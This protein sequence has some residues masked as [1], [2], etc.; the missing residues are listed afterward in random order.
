MEKMFHLKQMI[1]EKY[2]LIM[3]VRKYKG[4]IMKETNCLKQKKSLLIITGIAILF[5]ADTL[6]AQTGLEGQIHNTIRDLV[7]IINVIIIG[8][9]AWAGFLIAKGDGGGIERLLYGVVGLIVVNSAYMIINFF[10]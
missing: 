5:L 6:F 7:R 8:F 4:N 3:N 10:Q 1:K 2:I 9:I